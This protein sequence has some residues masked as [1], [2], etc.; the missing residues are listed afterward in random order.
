M[1][2]IWALD[3]DKKLLRWNS[4]REGEAVPC[5]L[6]QDSEKWRWIAWGV[7]GRW[8]SGVFLGL[9]FIW[10]GA[11]KHPALERLFWYLEVESALKDG[12]KTPSQRQTLLSQL[13]LCLPFHPHSF[14]SLS[15]GFC[16]V[17]YFSRMLIVSFLLLWA[18]WKQPERKD[19]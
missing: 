5:P 3:P 1:S 12:E 9:G 6:R 19:V 8:D 14:A 18:V 11:G 15:S 10:G 7:G 16:F 4:L 17:V 13:G 2:Q